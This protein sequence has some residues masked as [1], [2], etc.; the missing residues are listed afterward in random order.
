MKWSRLW[1]PRSGLFWLMLVFNALSSLCA[2]ALR[3][4]PLSVGVQWLVALV[5]LLNVAF[6]LL[7]AWQLLRSD[8]PG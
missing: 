6:G 4:L 8:P 1:Q 3:T 2:W 7:A 5:A